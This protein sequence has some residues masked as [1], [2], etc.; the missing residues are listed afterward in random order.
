MISSQI[1][2]DFNSVKY[3]IPVSDYNQSNN[4]SKTILET[5]Q[6]ILSQNGINKLNNHDFFFIYNG[7]LLNPYENI[8]TISWKAQLNIIECFLAI[9]G[10]NPLDDI[11]GAIF[12]FFD[13]IVKPINA[14]GQV[15]IFLMQI[16]VWLAKFIYW[17]IFFI[18][19]LFSDLLNPIKLVADFWN[20]ILLIMMTLISTLLQIPRALAAFVINGVGGWMQGFFGWDQSNLTKRDKN[21][22]YFKKM[23]RSKGKKCYLTNNNTVPFSILLGTIICPPIGVFMDL[24]MTG[25]MNIFICGLLTLFFYIPG[26]LYALLV[27][28]S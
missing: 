7:K 6:N 16:L 28:Y 15:F 20:S 24:G 13:P 1:Y 21:S 9:P 2:F 18:I 10:G 14:I 26:L 8:N 27:I 11:L 19:W 17:F 4:H 3:R 23:D 25:W 12:A 5:F 22:R